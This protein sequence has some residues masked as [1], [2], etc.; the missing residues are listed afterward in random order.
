[1]IKKFNEELN[2]S[3]DKIVLNLTREEAKG[4][5]HCIGRTMARGN[6][7][8]IGI[9]IEDRLVELLKQ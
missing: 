2:I 1:M 8:T 6:N 3:D 7:L 4:L 9:E 5:L